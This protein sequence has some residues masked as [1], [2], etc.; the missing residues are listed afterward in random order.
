MQIG[1]GETYEETQERLGLQEL[2]K[3]LSKRQ[4]I[5]R[6]IVE[7]SLS[8]TEKIRKPFIAAGSAVFVPLVERNIVKPINP[9]Y[10]EG[11]ENAFMELAKDPSIL[12]II[13]S[14]H[15]G[16]AD[17]AGTAVV[18]KQLTE[19]ANRVRPP[20]NQFRGFMLTVAA[21]I[22]SAHQNIFL[23]QSIRRAK[24]VLYKRYHLPLG[25]YARKKD[26]EKYQIDPQTINRDFAEKTR[27]IMAGNEERIADGYAYYVEGTVEGG[28]RI[29]EG[30]N[31]GQTKGTQKI[32]FESY[33]PL[34]KRAQLRNHRKVVIIT[35]SSDGASEI[36]DP[37]Q[38]N[39]KPSRKAI[40]TVANPLPARKSLLT[41]KVGDPIFYDDIVKQIEEKTG[42]EATTEEIGDEI[43]RRISSGLPPEKR[44]YYK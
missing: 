10:S 6:K 25:D 42:K 9:E 29:K 11:F 38:A 43:G 16:H 13:M 23:Q 32:D 4:K 26:V 14:N 40:M 18:S 39:I 5:K 24:G 8:A 7:K 20:E 37:D 28:R 33:E 35:V 31:K 30:E 15:T 44:G 12:F 19:L 27:N 1:F 21:S 36:L 3:N 41:V 34:I 22:E 17:A 2:E